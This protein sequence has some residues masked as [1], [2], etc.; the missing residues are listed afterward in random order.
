[1]RTLIISFSSCNALPLSWCWNPREIWKCMENGRIF[2]LNCPSKKCPRFSFEI[3]I[4][5]V[6]KI[7][8]F[9]DQHKTVHMLSALIVSHSWKKK[10]CWA[11]V[12]LPNYLWNKREKPRCASHSNVFRFGNTMFTLT[13]VGSEEAKCGKHRVGESCAYWSY[14]SFLLYVLNRMRAVFLL[15]VRTALCAFCLCKTFCGWHI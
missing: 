12:A 10:S 15:Y 14:C 9:C 3:M 6:A 1:M 13:I 8:D 5:F 7:Y 4:F 11:V 2:L